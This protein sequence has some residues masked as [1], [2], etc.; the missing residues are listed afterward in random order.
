MS[1]EEHIKLPEGSIE[2]QTTTLNL[3]PNFIDELTILHHVQKAGI[4]AGINTHN[5]IADKMVCNAGKLHDD[6]TQV[7]NALG[8]LNT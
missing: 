3:F 5:G 7:I 1:V 4:S 6:H 8:R 2:K